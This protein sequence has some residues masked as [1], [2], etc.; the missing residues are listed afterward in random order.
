MD[1]VYIDGALLGI[2]FID[3]CIDKVYI[4]G[5]LFSIAK[6]KDSRQD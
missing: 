2:C 4:D 6:V 1:K 5:S 3:K